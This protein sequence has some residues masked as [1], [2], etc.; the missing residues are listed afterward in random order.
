MKKAIF[1]QNSN[2]SS[3]AFSHIVLLAQFEISYLYECIFDHICQEER[4]G[5]NRVAYMS[6]KTQFISVGVV[7]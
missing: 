2:G 6:I 4:C 7:I 3:A 1:T 5:T